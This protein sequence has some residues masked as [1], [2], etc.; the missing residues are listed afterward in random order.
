MREV[1]AVDGGDKHRRQQRDRGHGEQ[2]HNL[3]LVDVY[4]AD[5]GDHQEVDLVEQEAGQH[6]GVKS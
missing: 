2:A 4:E 1:H 3:V 5:G 6:K